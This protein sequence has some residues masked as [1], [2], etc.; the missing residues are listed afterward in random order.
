VCGDDE[1]LSLCRDGEYDAEEFPSDR[2]LAE[3]AT[4]RGG[5]L[6]SEVP[7]P[8]DR[9]DVSW[10]YPVAGDGVRRSLDTSGTS[11]RIM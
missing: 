9:L 3:I 11:P 2:A 1:N 5:V 10:N 7:G 4:P 8:E 6:E